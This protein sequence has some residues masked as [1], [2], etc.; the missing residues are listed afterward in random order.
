MINLVRA[1]RRRS[2]RIVGS[3]VVDISSPASAGEQIE[4]TTVRPPLNHPS[5][6]LATE[7]PLLSPNTEEIGR[8]VL[9]I[10][11]TVPS[12]GT[13]RTDTARHANALPTP[14][15][16]ERAQP[17][18]ETAVASPTATGATHTPD[19]WK[20]LLDRLGAILNL[21]DAIPQVCV[22]FLISPTVHPLYPLCGLRSI[23]TLVWR[24]EWCRW[25]ARY[26]SGPFFSVPLRLT[27]F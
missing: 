2:A 7:L 22:I 9:S 25:H 18:T 21:G 24:G 5:N 27:Q 1:H 6:F 23:L 11:S 15:A 19:L 4:L 8:I 26:V 13:I 14:D 12:M 10:N 3:C 17:S 16:A 20:A